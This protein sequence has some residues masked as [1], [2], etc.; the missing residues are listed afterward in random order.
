MFIE[1]DDI[2][3]M[4]Q[5]LDETPLKELYAEE[6]IKATPMELVDRMLVS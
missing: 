2:G 1:L 6:M 4:E 5:C 3:V